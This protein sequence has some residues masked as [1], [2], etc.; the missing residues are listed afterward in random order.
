MAFTHWPTLYGKQFDLMFDDE[1]DHFDP[2][3]I[4]NTAFDGCP[5]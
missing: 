5:I 1:L 3:I 2:D 4:F